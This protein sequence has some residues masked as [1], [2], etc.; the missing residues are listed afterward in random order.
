MKDELKILGARIRELRQAAGISQTELAE[1]AGLH[2]T[3]VGGVERG[4]RN[5]CLLNI[6]RIARALKVR[7]AELLANMR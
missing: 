4:E 2:H 1:R 7:P 5:V 3:Y 6:A